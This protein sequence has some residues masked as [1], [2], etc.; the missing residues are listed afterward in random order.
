MSRH[1]GSPLPLESETDGPRGKGNETAA[2]RPKEDE[3]GVQEVEPTWDRKSA[4]V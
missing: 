3:M 1:N 4:N 2:T